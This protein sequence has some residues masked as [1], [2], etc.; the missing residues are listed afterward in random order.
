VERELR[1]CP[2]IRVFFTSPSSRLNLKGRR[3]ERKK[4]LSLVLKLL[5]LSLANNISSSDKISWRFLSAEEHEPDIGLRD[6][7]G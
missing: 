3:E 1:Q 2:E 7:V 5:L 6:I 4:E